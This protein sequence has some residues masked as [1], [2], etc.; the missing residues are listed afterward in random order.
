VT[1]HTQWVA[2]GPTIDPR[3]GRYHERLDAD[4]LPRLERPARYVGPYA[5]YRIATQPA[6]AARVALL[7]PSVP[8][9]HRLP[10]RLEPVLQAIETRLRRPVEVVCAPAADLSALL[11]REGLRLFS[12]PSWLPLTRFGLAVAWLEQPLQVLGL[13]SILEAAGLPARTRDR[14]LGPRLWAAGPA[15]RHLA[16]LLPA[17]VDTV[18]ADAVDLLAERVAEAGEDL[19]EA[20]DALDGER[21]PEAVASPAAEVSEG[22]VEA[23]GARPVLEGHL[24]SPLVSVEPLFGGARVTRLSLWASSRPLRHRLGRA[25][26]SLGEVCREALGHESR[27][28]EVD[29]AVGLPGEE[30]ADRA[31]H[32]AL[33]DE[34]IRIAPR[35]ARQI[36]V[37]LA[38]YVGPDAAPFSR[39]EAW[40]SRL[41]AALRARRVTVERADPGE[42]ALARLL[43]EEATG[44]AAAVEAVHAGGAVHGELEGARDPASWRPFLDDPSRLAAATAAEEPEEDTPAAETGLEEVPPVPATLGAD[45]ERLDAP[46]PSRDPDPRRDR[47]R[48]WSNLV[49][50]EFPVRLEYSRRGRVRHLSHRETADLLMEACRSAGIPLVVAGV[51]SPRPKLGFG[52]SLPVGVEGLHEFVD[53]SLT[54]KRPGIVAALNEHLPEGFAVRRARY[55]PAG[56]VRSLVPP[57]RACYQARIPAA[58]LPALRQALAR[59][60]QVDTWE[61]VRERGGRSQIV[62][63]KAQVRNV[64]LEETEEHLVFDLDLEGEGLRARP[65]EVLQALLT[66]SGIDVRTV[67]LIRTRL[68]GRGADPLAPWREPMEM[69]DRALR[70]ARAAARRHG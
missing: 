7:W 38:P 65:Q 63:L 62:D 22:R 33:V 15:A 10:A 37:R 70:R 60:S 20:T 67:P 9:S 27:R 55:L 58:V 31:A 51:V 57:Q 61:L 8:E 16:A 56:V 66:D 3:R 42:H 64:R 19:P 32:R 68:L 59:W 35:G 11:R 47:W 53:L 1:H 13:L 39:Q 23:E 12:R 34:L 28:L 36:R 30:T 29:L 44:L 49:P 43:G 5:S 24:A 21:P 40:L 46:A 14:F 50:R 25:E 41:D 26:R 52:P 48:R 6:A 4:I 2:S 18:H 69:V 45:G 17:W 54:S